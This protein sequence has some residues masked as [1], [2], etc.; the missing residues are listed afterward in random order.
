[1][2]FFQ[3]RVSTCLIFLPRY[4]QRCQPLQV[5][6]FGTCLFR[7]HPQHQQLLPTPLP[8]PRLLR[9]LRSLRSL[10][11]LES[12]RF[13]DEDNYEY[14]FFPINN[15]WKRLSKI[16]CPVSGAQI[17]IVHARAIARRRT[18]LFR[19]RILFAAKHFKS[20]TRFEDIAH[21][22][23]IICEQLFA[24]HVMDFWPMKRKK[25]LHR[26]IIL[27][28]AHA[29]SSLILGGKSDSRRHLARIS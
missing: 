5:K 12:F 29:W 22:Q 21:E 4:R 24:G 26:M 3:G 2:E 15:Y 13:L 8:P 6:W 9:S 10:P 27:S 28:I 25:N 7:P 20:Q 1:M 18:T 11:L 16:S 19:L 23:T 14:E 17:A